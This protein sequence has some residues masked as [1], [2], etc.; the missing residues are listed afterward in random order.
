MLT[1]NERIAGGWF[2]VQQGAVALSEDESLRRRIRDAKP[3]ET[4]RIEG[5]RFTEGISVPAGVNVELVGC[6]FNTSKPSVPGAP[7]IG[8][9]WL[10]KATGVTYIYRGAFNNEPSWLPVDEYWGGAPR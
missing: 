10:D 6:E 9:Q 7:P 8:K 5:M 2:E 3:G 4:I 1:A